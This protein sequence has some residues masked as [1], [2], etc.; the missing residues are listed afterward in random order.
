MFMLHITQTPDVIERLRTRGPQLIEALTAKMT[1][2]MFKLQSKIVGETIPAFFPNGAPNI[3]ASVRAIPAV[4]EGTKITG[5]V[6]AGGPRTTKE[7][8]GGP[9]AGRLVDYALVQ[10][11]GVY[12]SWTIQPV[13]YSSAFA[14]SQKSRVLSVKGL[15]KALAFLLNGKLMIL[16]SVTHPGLSQRPFMRY[17]LQEMEEQIVAGLNQTLADQL[18]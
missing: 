17:G 16:R 3:A 1:L 10:E 2:L 5:A 8:L 18:S 15:P 11:E 7:T 9:N 4:A 12:H 14:L 6:E 13:L